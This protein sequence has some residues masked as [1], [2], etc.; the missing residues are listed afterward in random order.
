[1]RLKK[2]QIKLFSIVA[3][4]SIG[5]IQSQVNADEISLTEI[6]WNSATHGDATSSKNCSDKPTLYGWK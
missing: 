1:M 4:M 3:L 6:E 5:I 2:V